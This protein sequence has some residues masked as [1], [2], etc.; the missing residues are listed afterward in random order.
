MIMMMK[1]MMTKIMM[2][3]M[4]MMMKVITTLACKFRCFT[5]N[6]AIYAIYS[7]GN[8][9]MET[10]LKPAGLFGSQCYS[11]KLWLQYAFILAYKGACTYYITL[12]G[13][14][15]GLGFC[16]SVLYMV[17]EVVLTFVI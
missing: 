16:Y 14:G 10:G 17:G 11:H 6:L 3:K 2:T 5:C 4:M 7:L 15:V 9:F 8:I 1:M 12:M 13:W